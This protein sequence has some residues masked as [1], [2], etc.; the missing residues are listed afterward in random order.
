[1]P[2]KIGG[3]ATD[4]IEVGTPRVL[5]G[6]SMQRMRP[7]RPGC[8]IAAAALTEIS[9]DFP[10]TFG[11]LVQD[12]AGKLFFLSNNHVLAVEELCPLGIVLPAPYAIRAGSGCFA[13][14]DAILTT[15]AEPSA[16]IFGSNA[17]QARTQ[18]IRLLSNVRAHCSSEK[19]LEWNRIRHAQNVEPQTRRPCVKWLH[20]C[21][22]QNR[23]RGESCVSPYFIG[24]RI[25]KAK[26]RQ[27]RIAAAF[28]CCG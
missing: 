27:S 3:F 6:L 4:V 1:M 24:S 19:A 8:T 22:Q 2:A 23:I 9:G 15:D 13:R 16:A 28:T 7:A 25:A 20:P 21:L 5:R 10:G 11:A 18:R 12:A 17:R 26:F 14:S